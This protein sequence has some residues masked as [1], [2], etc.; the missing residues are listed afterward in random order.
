MSACPCMYV[1]AIADVFC[2]ESSGRKHY[3][4]VINWL[5]RNY[6]SKQLI[7]RAQPEGEV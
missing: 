5:S 7:L 6:G 1:C 2:I 4:L 3:I